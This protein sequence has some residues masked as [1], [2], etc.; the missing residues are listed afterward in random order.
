MMQSPELARKNSG[1]GSLMRVLGSMMSFTSCSSAR[2][3]ACGSNQPCL[4]TVSSV[5]STA[6]RYLRCVRARRGRGRRRARRVF[7]LRPL[8]KNSGLPAGGGVC[9]VDAGGRTVLVGAQLAIPVVL[10]VRGA[11]SFTGIEAGRLSSPCVELHRRRSLRARLR[12]A[13][14]PATQLVPDLRHRR[15]RVRVL[16][17][18]LAALSCARCRPWPALRSTT[19]WLTR[20]VSVTAGLVRLAPGLALDR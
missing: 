18:D 16:R 17:I 4:L 13:R 20:R 14:V 6:A 8:T 5:C 19:S 2:M 15:Q 10:A 9:R 1:S 3:R 11:V 12:A 7:G